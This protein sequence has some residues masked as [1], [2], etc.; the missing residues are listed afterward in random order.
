M[1]KSKRALRSPGV[2]QLNGNGSDGV[3]PTGDRAGQFRFTSFQ[4]EMEKSVAS[5]FRQATND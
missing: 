5:C 3:D 4:P 1:F 2:Q